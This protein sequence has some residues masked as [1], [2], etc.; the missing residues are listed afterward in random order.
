[1]G[2]ECV[3]AERLH[4]SHTAGSC[5]LGPFRGRTPA[6]AACQVPGAQGSSPCGANVTAPHSPGSVT[7]SRRSQ[8]SSGASLLITRMAWST[9]KSFRIF[10]HSLGHIRAILCKEAENTVLLETRPQPCCPQR[11]SAGNVCVP[12]QYRQPGRG[13]GELY[14]PPAA[15]HACLVRRPSR[16]G[17]RS[18]EAT[19]TPAPSRSAPLSTLSFQEKAQEGRHSQFRVFL[20][21]GSDG[22][23]QSTVGA[24]QIPVSN[25]R[26][27]AASRGPPGRRQEREA[28]I[29]ETPFGQQKWGVCVSEMERG[30]GG[31]ECT[32]GK[33]TGKPR[34]REAIPRRAALLGTQAQ[35]ELRRRRRRKAAHLTNFRHSS[36]KNLE[37]T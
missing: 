36:T 35:T 14:G 21:H 10:S 11:P 33:L 30:G 4:L 26:D 32:H 17:P 5:P 9:T 29:A 12:G 13:R 23:H 25:G 2:A 1:M 20:G 19:E 15:P 34:G 7:Y 22:E 8:P 3:L 37:T 31:D 16:P 18:A 24:E 27:G 28:A 6:L